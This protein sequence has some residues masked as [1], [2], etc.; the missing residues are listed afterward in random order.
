MARFF[1]YFVLFTIFVCAVPALVR[2]DDM[3]DYDIVKFRSLDKI[4]ARTQTFEV[5]VGSTVQYGSIYIK[6]QACRKNP[7]IETPESAAFVQIWEI[8]T[9]GKAEWIFSGWMFA[10]SP[11]LSAMDHAVYDVWVL[12]CMNTSDEA[13]KA[14]EE[15]VID[16]DIAPE[17]KGVLTETDQD[18][19]EMPDEDVGEYEE[20]DDH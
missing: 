20:S 17:S 16:E 5:K 2:A 18:I 8:S 13:D 14:A 10:S 1:Q 6:V 19:D 3:I 9:E 15:T 7:P 11:G 4:S 12:D